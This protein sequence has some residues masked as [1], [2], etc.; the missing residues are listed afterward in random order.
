MSYCTSTTFYIKLLLQIIDNVLRCDFSTE[1]LT[2]NS[3]EWWTLQYKLI[4]KFF[5]EK[6]EKEKDS[7]HRKQ[8]KTIII[9]IIANYYVIFCLILAMPV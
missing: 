7:F 5:A 4:S 2:N 8:T 6:E 1:R 3:I 9:I